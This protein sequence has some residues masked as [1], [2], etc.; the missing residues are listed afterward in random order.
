[1]QERDSRSDRKRRRRGPARHP[2]ESAVKLIQTAKP[3]V[4]QNKSADLPLTAAEAAQMRIH[5]RFLREHRKVLALKVNA[6]EDLLLNGAREPTHRGVCQHLLD[7]V[8]RSR[9]ELAAQRLDPASRTRML[10]GIIR[11]SPDIAYLLLY[12]ESLKDAARPDAVAALSEALRRIDFSA[13]SAAQM[14]R[15]LDLIVELTDERARPDLLFSLLSSSTFQQAFDASAEKLPE[16]LANIVVPLRSAHAVIVRGAPNPFDGAALARGASMLL[17]LHESVLRAQTPAVARRLFTVGIELA[18]EPAAKCATGLRTLLESFPKE[19]RVFGDAARSLLG[20]LLSRGLDR[21]TR[22]LISSLAKDAPR[23][24][25]PRHLI[26]ALD[27]PRIGG[28]GLSERAPARDD[29]RPARERFSM[30][31]LLKRQQSVWVRIGTPADVERYQRAVELT[32][33]L[34]LPGVASVVAH[35]LGQ[36]GEPYLAMARHGRAANELILGKGGLSAPT[37]LGL[38]IEAACILGA[39]ALAGVR[40][41]DARFRRFAVDEQGRLWLRDLMDAERADD[42]RPANTEL[43]RELC[44][45]VLGR[46][47]RLLVPD[48]I[49][50]RLRRAE[51]CV[52]LVRALEALG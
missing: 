45:E 25:V 34:A 15:V 49:A 44:L 22:A 41:P 23:V 5:L 42:A 46:V 13:V 40:L 37:G 3:A 6:A 27:G 7:K 31:V 20:W 52:G 10:E 47:E 14:R 29:T 18:E 8:E 17:G 33:S 19:D 2:T 26:T 36:G 21:E 50:E 4:D 30:G 38:C 9:V 48:A 39:L 35:G 43:A 32:A 28:I 24:E 1:M 16:A 11:F 51:D 12:L